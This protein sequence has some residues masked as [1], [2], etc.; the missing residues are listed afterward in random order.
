V[1]IW[2]VGGAKAIELETPQSLWLKFNLSSI[3]MPNFIT[4]QQA[5][6]GLP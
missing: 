4:F 2:T 3:H 6:N 1:K 5:V